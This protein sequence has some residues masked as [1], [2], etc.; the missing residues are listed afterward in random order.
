MGRAMYEAVQLWVTVIAVFVAV[1][2]AG[3]APSHVD[4]CKLQGDRVWLGYC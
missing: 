4:P 2:V 3:A 1:A